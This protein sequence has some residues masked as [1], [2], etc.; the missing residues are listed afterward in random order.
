MIG[1]DTDAWKNDLQHLA[2]T[3]K[4]YFITFVTHNR[5][6]LSPAERDIVLATIRGS[7]RKS[8]YLHAAVIMPDHVHLL[9]TPYEHITLAELMQQLKSISAHRIA[10]HRAGKTR[11][12][13]REYF[14]RIMRTD[15]DLRAKG[16]Y[17]IANPIRAGLTSE[18]TD[19]PWLYR[20][21]NDDIAAAGA[22]PLH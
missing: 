16:E 22:P 9:L 13:Q 14:D 21:W 11:I 17:L 12:W 20:S 3:G 10:K 5:E 2:K 1:E 6:V 8:M 15:E 7:H 4:T 19:Y 18:V